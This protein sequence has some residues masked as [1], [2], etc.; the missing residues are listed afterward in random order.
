MEKRLVIAGMACGHC[1]AHVERALNSLQG[2]QARVDLA[3]K[4]A[5]VRSAA[6]VSDEVLRQTVADAGYEVI[7]IS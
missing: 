7:S 1:A 3:T 6:E 2:V 5:V 4:T